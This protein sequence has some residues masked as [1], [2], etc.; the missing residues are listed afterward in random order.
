MVNK[1]H[2]GYEAIINPYHTM[3]KLSGAE[4]LEFIPKVS[5][6]LAAFPVTSGLLRCVVII[7]S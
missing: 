5:H 6:S 2:K 4:T 3:V 1:D 7:V